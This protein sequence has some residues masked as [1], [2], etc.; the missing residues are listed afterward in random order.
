MTEPSICK[1]EE[2]ATIFK[3]HL[4]WV[5]LSEAAQDI[6]AIL[7][8]ENYCT[9][10]GLSPEEIGSITGYARSSIS[11]IL[12]QL[13]ILGL[14]EG[15]LDLER[16]GQGRRR[17]IFHVKGGGGGLTL[18][19]VRRLA[20]E[21]Q[22]LLDELEVLRQGSMSDDEASHRMLEFI[23]VETTTNLAHLNKCIKWINSTK[24]VLDQDSIQSMK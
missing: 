7:M 11:V 1:N 17:K 8:V 6:I 3:T 12:S 14:I 4:R 24:A 18:F 19:G 9:G 13:K 23:E 21:L 16:K 20:V 22:S 10:G 2:L 15:K 5:G